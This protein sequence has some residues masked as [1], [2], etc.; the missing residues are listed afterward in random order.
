MT[1]LVGL[2]QF[3]DSTL[4]V[5]LQRLE[6]FSVSPATPITDCKQPINMVQWFPWYA[7]G[8][9][10]ELSFARRLGFLDTQSDVGGTC[11]LLN[12]FT[13]YSSTFASIL[14]MH[15][16]L[17]GSPLINTLPPCQRV[18][19]QTLPQQKS[20]TETSTSTSHVSTGGNLQTSIC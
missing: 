2:E 11:K 20:I 14:E 10:G 9:I 17:L 6:E 19:L 13:A 12:Q 8:V 1:S 18:S 5:F 15:K 7:F 3:V 4:K 16:D